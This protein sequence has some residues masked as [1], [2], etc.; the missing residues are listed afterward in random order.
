MSDKVNFEMI[1]NQAAQ[2]P[3][4][5]IDRREFLF[6]AFNKS[7]DNETM[8]RILEYGPVH[9]GINKNKIHKS[10]KSSIDFETA[11]VTA[12]STITG[13]P[14]GLAVIGTIPAD[15]AQFYG[16]ILRIAQKLAYLY[17]YPELS[18]NGEIDDAVKNLL[19]LFIGVMSG[20]QAAETAVAKISASLAAK[21][22]NQLPKTALTKGVVYPIV[23]KVARAFGANMTRDI[24]AKGV[25]KAI[26]IMGGVISGALTLATFKPMANRLQKHLSDIVF[27]AIDFAV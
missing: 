6:S 24:F 18:D 10:A 4:V 15:L 27:N 8:D 16:H 3:L 11:K 7:Y 22:V 1:I 23:K 25:G 13:V 17:G 21:A 20:V 2:L 5:K 26:P 19:I 14:S 9:A 12:I